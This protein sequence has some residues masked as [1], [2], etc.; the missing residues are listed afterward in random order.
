MGLTPCSPWGHKESDMTD[1]LNPIIVAQGHWFMS[2]LSYVFVAFSMFKKKFVFV[3]KIELLDETS[4][5]RDSG[6]A[7]GTSMEGWIIFH[8]YQLSL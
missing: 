8:D 6:R 1:Q 3:M 2:I 7:S 4:S 5:I